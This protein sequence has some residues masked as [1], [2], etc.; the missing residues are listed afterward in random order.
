MKFHVLGIPHTVSTPEYSSCAF[1]QKVV[2]LCAMLSMEGHEV[3]HYGHALSDVYGMNVAVTNT[4][5]LERS[6]PGHNWRKNGWPKFARTDLV[7]QILL[8]NGK[9]L[10]HT[11]P[12]CL[13][14][15]H[16]YRQNH[17]H[18]SGTMQPRSTSFTSLSSQQV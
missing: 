5:D 12:S 6:Y 2:K 15:F 3:I 16:S 9:S 13:H 14:E 7:Y 1:T 8:T 10:T 11:C 4:A 18:V 17:C